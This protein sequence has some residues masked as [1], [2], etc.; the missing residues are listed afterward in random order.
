MLARHGGQGRA[1]DAGKDLVEQFD[2]RHLQ[3]PHVGKG[4][5]HLQADKARADNGHRANTPGRHRCLDGFGRFQ[6]VDRVHARQVKPF[7]GE[8]PRPAAHGQDQLVVGDGFFPAGGQMLGRNGLGRAVNG[9][10]LG[11]V[12]GVHVFDIAEKFG[13]AHHVKG[14]G[15]Q[16]RDFADL[17]GNVVGNAAAAV[18]DAR[19]AVQ[20]DDVAFRLQPFETAGGLGSQG[21]APDDDNLLR[22]DVSLRF[23]LVLGVRLG[24]GIGRSRKIHTAKV[25]NS[26]FAGGLPRPW[27]CMKRN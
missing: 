25:R 17:A 16:A 22:H 9:C 3:P 15:L 2:D 24:Y 20:H 27:T 19:A 7:D 5:S 13:I 23:A 18:G 21:D 12:A 8:A 6:A 1:G 11:L 14:R 10:H 4:H 26:R